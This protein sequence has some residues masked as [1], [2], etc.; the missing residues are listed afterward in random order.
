MLAAPQGKQ[1]ARSGNMGNMGNMGKH[2]KHDS[3]RTAK[4]TQ[5]TVVLCDMLSSIKF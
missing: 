1:F 4:L 2:E 5:A 3:L